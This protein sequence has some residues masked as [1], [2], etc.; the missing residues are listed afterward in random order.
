MK[1]NITKGSGG[2]LKILDKNNSSASL[3][4]FP[5]GDIYTLYTV[6]KLER[7]LARE[8]VDR[9]LFNS[10]AILEFDAASTISALAMSTSDLRELKRSGSL[11]AVIEMLRKFVNTEGA[12]YESEHAINLIKS[13]SILTEDVEQ[14]HRFVSNP[15]SIQCIL[16][17]CC[18]KEGSLQETCFEIVERISKLE[19]A[20][21]SLLNHNI[22][23]IIMRPELLLRGSTK[24]AVRRR[25]ANLVRRIATLFPNSFP[26]EV[27]DDVA[28][29]DYGERQIDGYVEIQ[30]LTSLLIA[31]NYYASSNIT[32]EL[33]LSLFVHFVREI[34]AET[35]ED[36]DHLIMLLKALVFITK[37]P[38]QVAFLVKYDLGVA[39]QYVVRTD[40][41]VWNKHIVPFK[42]KTT[43]D[44]AMQDREESAVGRLQSTKNF[45]YNKDSGKSHAK[46]AR[47]LIQTR[48]GTSK[49]NED[50]NF[51][52]A[53]LAVQIYENVISHNV[54]IIP[55]IS[56]SGLIPGLLFRV[57]KGA[58][59]DYRFCQL[60]I[61]F[62][63]ELVTL[64]SIHYTSNDKEKMERRQSASWSLSRSLSVSSSSSL[65]TKVQVQD[66][67]SS[68]G[69]A[70][71]SSNGSVGFSVGSKD[72]EKKSPVSSHSKSN[73]S[74]GNQSGNSASKTPKLSNENISHS[75]N[76]DDMED[77]DVEG[78]EQEGGTSRRGKTSSLPLAPVLPTFIVPSHSSL[79]S[80]HLRRLPTL[81][82]DWLSGDDS[83]D[84]RS[85]TNILN[86]HHVTEFLVQSLEEPPPSAVT[87]VSNMSGT[88]MN[89]EALH[90]LS[91]LHFRV[92]R[93]VLC[94]S[95]FA[96]SK[97]CQMSM[98][99]SG[100]GSDCFFS[101]LGII[102][103]VSGN[104]GVSEALSTI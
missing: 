30:L 31:F 24:I 26:I 96:I 1:K 79:E 45:D 63:F 27:F 57:G 4:M 8:V 49:K 89:V 11:G 78:R 43:L 101:G 56:A 55:D 47:S 39:L 10:S 44:Y 70:T 52:M 48:K 104:E 59:K 37:S 2:K 67:K 93:N 95:A 32:Y 21:S 102:C 51:T 6:D 68:S 12:D 84:M 54:R 90:T 66:K 18:L 19:N 13:L 103:D 16:R 14:Q 53:R 72:G 60:L 98:S 80:S 46:L 76:F 71:G 5:V 50:V 87:S 38:S 65:S 75:F 91:L 69:K 25:S 9:S 22:Y 41:E 86:A 15:H 28:L 20:V 94:T 99:S 23:S 85:L 17:L 83:F 73:N 82:E 74:N 42:S 35:F 81:K 62:I 58:N 3:K 61:H 92:I 97:V 36:L 77:D 40:F 29:N 33:N 100:S 7:D 34:I 64:V 88:P